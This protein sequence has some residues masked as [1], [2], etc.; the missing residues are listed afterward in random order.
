MLSLAF[1]HVH[2]GRL[3]CKERVG[4]HGRGGSEKGTSMH[5]LHSL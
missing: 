4:S 1:G 2:S 3:D 5:G